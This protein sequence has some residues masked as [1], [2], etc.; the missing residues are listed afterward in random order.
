[1]GVDFSESYSYAH[2]DAFADDL[3]ALPPD[4]Q[5]WRYTVPQS[6]S[7]QFD[8]GFGQKQGGADHGRWRWRDTARTPGRKIVRLGRE[9]RAEGGEDSHR[10]QRE[11]RG[12][13]RETSLRSLLSYRFANSV[14]IQRVRPPYCPASKTSRGDTAWNWSSFPNPNS[15]YAQTAELEARIPDFLI[16]E[17]IQYIQTQ[18]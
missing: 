9:R 7:C 2:T 12:R 1:M 17:L 5:Q 11:A 13:S 10:R 16:P 18:C 3:P 6:P 8:L 15:V 4:V 14:R